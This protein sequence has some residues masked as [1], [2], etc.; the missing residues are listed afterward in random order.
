MIGKAALAAWHRFNEELGC[1]DEE[2]CK[3]AFELAWRARGEADLAVTQSIT[4]ADLRR[5]ILALDD[6]A[7]LWE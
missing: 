2:Y 6:P 3:R 5:R 1:V 7:G 4:D